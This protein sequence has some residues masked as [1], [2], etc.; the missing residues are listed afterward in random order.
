MPKIKPGKVDIKRNGSLVNE[1]GSEPHV[2]ISNIIKVTHQTQIIYMM[3]TNG[4]KYR[5]DQIIQ[6]SFQIH[7]KMKLTLDKGQF[8]CKSLI[9]H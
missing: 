3:A 9:L 8:S 4:W 1:K 5:K 6:V 2:K 7:L